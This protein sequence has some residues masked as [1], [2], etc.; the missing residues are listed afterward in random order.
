MLSVQEVSA[1]QP[2][3]VTCLSYMYVYGH[4]RKALVDY[5]NFHQK[6][7]RVFQTKLFGA[8]HDICVTGTVVSR[9]AQDEAPGRGCGRGRGRG[10]GRRRGGAAR[11]RRLH[12]HRARALAALLGTTAA[13]R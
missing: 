8:H 7:K 12:L 5:T 4:S 2:I 11:A 9:P 3:V 1:R 6:I 13:A 10:P